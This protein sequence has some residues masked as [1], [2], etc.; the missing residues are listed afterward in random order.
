M[1]LLPTAEQEEITASIATFLRAELP[2]TRVRELGAG[3]SSRDEVLWRKC[4]ELGWFG[5]ALADDVGGVGYGLAEEA[6]MFREIGRHLVPGPFL[7]T[8]LGARVATGAGARELAAEIIA[9]TVVVGLA[10]TNGAVT[11]GASLTAELSLY[12][13]VDADLIVVATP[14]LVAL[15]ETSALSNV[16]VHECID[17][18]TRIA[19][20]DAEGVATVAAVTAAADPLHLRGA[21]LVAAMASG[22]A[23]QARDLSAEHARTRVQFGKPIGVN[24]AV[25]HACTDM[26]VRAEA[27]TCQTFFAALALGDRTPDAG[28]QVAAAKVVATNAAML[29]ARASVQIHGGIGFTWEHDAHLLAKRAHV[30]GVLFGDRREHLAQLLALPPAQRGRT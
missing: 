28:F 22:V 20:A 2:M 14:D 13:A 12:D 6:M 10:Q 3:S 18:L 23:E 9:G 15:Y 26:A 8:V 21:V 30:L 19:T 11:A 1:D 29:N 27:A 25:K 24:Q 16:V 17:P 7:G 5:L 4:A